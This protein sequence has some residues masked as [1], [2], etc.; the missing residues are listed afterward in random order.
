MASVAYPLE[1]AAN[2]KRIAITADSRVRLLSKVILT[3]KRQASMPTKCIDQIAVNP[4]ATLAM[5]VHI[6]RNNAFREYLAWMT[7]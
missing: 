1:K 5:N 7:I 6:H 4:N 2:V 3:S